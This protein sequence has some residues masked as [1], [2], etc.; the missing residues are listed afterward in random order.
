MPPEKPKLPDAVIADFVKWIELGAPDPREE[1]VPLAESWPDEARQHWA[2]QPI[3]GQPSRLSQELEKGQARRLSYETAI[4]AFILAKLAARG[5]TH[6]PP[7]S[8][9]ELIRRLSFDLI[10]LPPTPEEIE[11]FAATP[12]RRLRAARRSAAGQPAVRRARAQHWLD[13]VRYA[14]TEGF[15]YDRHV[16]DAWRFRDYVIDA[17]QPRQAVRPSSSASRSP[18]TRSARATR[19]A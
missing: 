15:E 5:W 14:E 3:V 9:P 11:A 13:V 16:P 17:L 6:S 4:D 10:G 18:A 8:R 19:S 12:A 1:A 2:F 7:A